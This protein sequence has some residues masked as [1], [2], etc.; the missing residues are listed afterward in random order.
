MVIGSTLLESD[1]PVFLTFARQGSMALD[2][3]QLI[4]RL[5]QN[6]KRMKGLSQHI[7]YAQEQERR[8]IGLELHDEI[9]Q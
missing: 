6:E 9:G 2:N 7:L 4:Q 1:V 5:R 8:Q 3:T